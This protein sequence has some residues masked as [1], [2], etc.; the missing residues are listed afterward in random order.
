M[1]FYVDS[2]RVPVIMILHAPCLS[3]SD[4]DP[5]VHV[6]VMPRRVS[7]MGWVGPAVDLGSDAAEVR[8][9]QARMAHRDTHMSS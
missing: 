5:H 8:A 2:E 1:S 6:V 3:G 7:R 9:R 4:A